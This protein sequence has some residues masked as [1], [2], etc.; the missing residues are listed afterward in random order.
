MNMEEPI[1][2]GIYARQ[3]TEKQESLEFQLESIRNYCKN[4]NY[5][6]VGEYQDIMSGKTDSRPE[7]N[8]MLEDIRQGKMKAVIV[9]KLDR[10]G[11]SMQHLLNLFE[12]FK[13]DGV[14]FISITQNFNTITPEGKLMLRMLMI[15]AEYERELIVARTKDKLDY[16]NEQIDKH[17]FFVTKD[18]RKVQKLGRPK[19]SKDKKVRRVS[20]Y[21]QR[22]TNK[23]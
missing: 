20:G 14:D 7:F 8:K 16:Y 3:S 11:R 12:E 6:I 2:V 22:W 1:K 9:Y 10:I 18:G 15:L 13:N 17:G 4:K 5:E 21:H 19:G 23:K